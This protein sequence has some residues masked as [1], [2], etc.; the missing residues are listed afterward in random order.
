MSELN[1]T[2]Y[3]TLSVLDEI[4]SIHFVIHDED[5]DW[6]F[7]PNRAVS[8]GDAALASLK[9]ILEIDATIEDVLGLPDSHMVEKT[10]QGKWMQKK[11]S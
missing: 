11:I 4:E 10:E 5:G 6:H 3:T 2:V 8:D 9:Q 7:M 1:K